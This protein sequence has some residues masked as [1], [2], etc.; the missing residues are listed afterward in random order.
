HLRDALAY[1][2]LIPQ[3]EHG[4]RL[5]CA[6]AIGMAVLTLDKVNA[7]LDFID[8]REVK[9]SHSAVTW[10][11]L[12]TRASVRSDAAL[13]ALF[14]RAAVHLPAPVTRL[15]APL[16]Q[17]RR[18]PALKP[19]P[20]SRLAPA[21]NRAREALL[22][23]QQADGHWCFEL[24]ADCTIP[25][26]YILMMHYMDEIDV[27]LE[28]RIAQFLRAH[29]VLGDHG[30]WPLYS[31]S[32]ID[33]S[34]TVKCYYALKLVGDDP[35]APHMQRAREAIHKLGGAARANVFTKIMMAQFGQIP[36]R[37]V[38]FI[39]AEIMLLPK[40]FVFHLDKVSYWARTVMVPLFIL[41]SRRAQAKNPRGVGIAELFV[42]PPEQERHYLPTHDWLS[43]IFLV[44]DRA[45]RA[46]EPYVA[47]LLRERA[48]KAAETWFVPRLNGEDGLGAIFPAMVNA[49]E[50]MAELGYPKDHPA[51]AT[52]LKSIQKLL[53]EC[54]DGSVYC[55]PCVSPVWDTGWAALSLLH[56]GPKGTTDEPA[57]VAIDRALAWLA[58]LQETELK[59]DWSVR[60]PNVRPGGWAFQYR[61]AYYPDL[62]DTAMVTALLHVA[63]NG[64]Y[65]EHIARGAEWLAGM[66]S[67][68][69]AFGAFD[70]DNDFLYLN[71]I[72]FAD[73]GALCD[74]P[75]ADVSGRVL[76]ALGM[77][78]RREDR[79]AIRR[80]VAFL[81]AEQRADG[82]WWGR[83][84]TNY[85]Y[86]TWSVLAGL[87]FAGEDPAQPYIRRA[88][89]WLKDKQNSDGGWGET[90]DSY[91]DPTLA[92]NLNDESTGYTTAWALL[93][94]MAA[95]E[96]DSDA[97]RRGIRWLVKAQDSDGFWPHDTFTAPG[98]PR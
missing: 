94:L 57:R 11:T 21:I 50:A 35:D 2:L 8:G 66:Q 46:V 19:V 76:L 58:P 62:D 49:Y 79:D 4:I 29:Q 5:F 23:L 36:W 65:A 40:W 32:A 48:I 89:A 78:G 53:V 93:G 97:V 91:L 96:V 98:F 88:V 24:E 37:G 60:A 83:W 63:G 55:Q 43:R 67:T 41:I 16:P 30:G 51:R 1:M 81:R 82:A 80:C 44:A 87:A 45:G 84:G 39:P 17:Q 14:N 71:K 52:C 12:L 54:P 64:H 6:W 38:P 95:G 28:R 15:D 59:G 9:I 70:V 47:R 26:E 74:P 86:G 27:D 3:E 7:H 34:C 90:N 61:N 22:A 56:T 92:G 20:A 72:P 68:D 13:T 69:G 10:T 31:R 73:H 85:I 42:T 75:T 77:L 25:A 33:L 18:T